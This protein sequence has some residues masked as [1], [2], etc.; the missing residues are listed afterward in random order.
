MTRAGW[1]AASCAW[2][3]LGFAAVTAAPEVV[4]PW[5]VPV[6]WAVYLAV[7]A[8]LMSRLANRGGCL[9]VPALVP[10]LLGI[11]FLCAAPLRSEL[12]LTTRGTET[13]ATVTHVDVTSPRGALIARQ[14]LERPDGTPVAGGRLDENLKLD[15]GDHVTVL[16]DPRGELI[17]RTP[18]AADPTTRTLTLTALLGLCTS[19]VGWAGHSRRLRAGMVGARGSAGS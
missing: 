17:P 19:A 1:T 11:Y 2:L 12:L 15:T 8:A 10:A 5:L 7:L 9:L 6:C 4:H 13:R 16:E 18:A 3:P 14:T